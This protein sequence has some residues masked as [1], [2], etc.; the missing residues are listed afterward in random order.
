[1]LNTLKFLIV[2]YVIWPYPYPH[3]LMNRFFH[4]ILVAIDPFEKNRLISCQ[5]S[6]LD[7]H[8]D[9]PCGIGIYLERVVEPCIEIEGF[10]TLEDHAEFTESVRNR[11]RATINIILQ[12]T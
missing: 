10:V 5:D 9:R 4:E 12:T 1:M 2:E 6:C 11:G 8:V 7:Q 3:Q